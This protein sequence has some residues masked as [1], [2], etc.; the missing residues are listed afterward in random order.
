V[1]SDSPDAGNAASGIPEKAGND[2]DAAWEQWWDVQ[3]ALC[4]DIDQRLDEAARGRSRPFGAALTASLIE[5]LGE[6]LRSY[7]ELPASDIRDGDDDG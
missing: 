6:K 4:H 5:H 1:T 7:L 2:S 3:Y